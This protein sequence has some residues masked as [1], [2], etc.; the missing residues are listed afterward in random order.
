MPRVRIRK[1]GK[2]QHDD[3]AY[4]NA[5]ECILSVR[6]GLMSNALTE[7]PATYAIIVIP[8]NFIVA[9]IAGHLSIILRVF[10]LL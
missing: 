4:I 10:S 3:S 8:T 9:H 5:Y 7:N 2:G 6:T 1:T